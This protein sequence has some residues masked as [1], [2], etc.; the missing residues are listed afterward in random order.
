MPRGESCGPR[1][2]LA[3][4]RAAARTRVVVGLDQAG[5]ESCGCG[6]RR[7]GFESQLRRSVGV[8]GALRASSRSS[9]L[10]RWLGEAKCLRQYHTESAPLLTGR[11]SSRGAMDG[12]VWQLSVYGQAGVALSVYLGEQTVVFGFRGFLIIAL[13]RLIKACQDMPGTTMA[14]PVHGS[15][16]EACIKFHGGC[17]FERA[18]PP[19]TR[20]NPETSSTFALP[21]SVQAQ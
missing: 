18:R 9:G 7:Q 21:G 2:E 8:R 14:M 3:V 17:K 12:Q 5:E 20:G 13:S 19:F 16:K 15:R 1:A 10:R 6:V 11:G 4:P